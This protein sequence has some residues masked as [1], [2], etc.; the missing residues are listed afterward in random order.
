MAAVFG[1]KTP[2]AAAPWAV[3][4]TRPSAAGATSWGRL[5]AGTAYTLNCGSA[6]CGSGTEEGPVDSDEVVD[7]AGPGA[8]REE[9]FAVLTALGREDEQA[10]AAMREAATTATK[11]YAVAFKHVRTHGSGE[12]P[13]GDVD[14][15]SVTFDRQRL[16]TNGDAS[17][18]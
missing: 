10:V 14:L 3:Y 7:D 5:P 1:S 16:L 15:A 18:G 11:R 17:G 8:D 2:S 13:R 6:C 9:S 12:M 4:Q